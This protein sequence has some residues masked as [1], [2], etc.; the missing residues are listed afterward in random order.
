MPGPVWPVRT[1]LKLWIPQNQ[2]PE[3][4]RWPCSPCF[5]VEASPVPMHM[6]SRVCFFR[7]DPKV[8]CH[9]SGR[10]D[11]SNELSASGDMYFSI[12]AGSLPGPSRWDIAPF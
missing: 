1:L 9:K 12:P 6:L 10:S 4:K 5:S 11:K 3:K 2:G 8:T 7:I